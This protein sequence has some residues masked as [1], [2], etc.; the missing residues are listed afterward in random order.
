MRELSD[1]SDTAFAGAE[2]VYVFLSTHVIHL[3]DEEYH[4]FLISDHS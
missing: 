3:T 1:I 2:Q 4:I